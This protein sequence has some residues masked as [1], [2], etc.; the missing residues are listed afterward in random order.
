AGAGQMVGWR[1]RK[2][3]ARSGQSAGRGSGRKR[4]HSTG[5]VLK[6]SPPTNCGW[7]LA[8]SVVLAMAIVGVPGFALPQIASA[9]AAYEKALGLVQSGKNDDALLVIDSAIAAGARDSSL[10]NLKGLAE[11]EL[12]H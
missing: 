6:H 7:V 4:D 11:S 2:P 12:G 5:S 1:G 9:Q 10:Y 8:V 3:G